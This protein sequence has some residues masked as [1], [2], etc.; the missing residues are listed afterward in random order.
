MVL[1]SPSF[2]PFMSIAGDLHG[3][4]IDIFERGGFPPAAK[5]L[6]LG[7]YVDRGKRSLE[8]NTLAFS[9]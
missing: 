6:F 9:I 7:D 3:Q 4:Y 8:T 5:Y 2:L 1:N